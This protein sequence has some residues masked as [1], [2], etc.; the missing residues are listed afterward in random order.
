[1]GVYIINYLFTYIYIYVYIHIIYEMLCL[2][3]YVRDIG[4]SPTNMMEDDYN[5]AKSRKAN[6]PPFG[7]WF[8]PLISGKT[9]GTWVYDWVYTY[10]S[11]ARFWVCGEGCHNPSNSHQWLFRATSKNL[12]EGGEDVPMKQFWNN[13]GTV[14]PQTRKSYM[15]CSSTMNNDR[16]SSQYICASTSYMYINIY[17]HCDF[18]SCKHQES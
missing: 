14:R 13:S 10:V 18:H 3:G 9:W 8:M 17:T 1:M 7:R 5:K 6:Q 12:M 2:Y 16:V 15:S 11:V 4:I